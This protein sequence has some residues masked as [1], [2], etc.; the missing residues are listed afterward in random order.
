[1]NTATP[2]FA[3]QSQSQP[4]T[5]TRGDAPSSA[6]AAAGAHAEYEVEHD[7][8]YEYSSQVDFA[9]HLAHL[10]PVTAPG[11]A[12]HDFVLHVDPEPVRVDNTVDYFGNHR[13][14]F[15]LTVAHEVLR[16]RASSRVRLLPRFEELDPQVSAPWEAVRSALQYE[17]GAAFAPAA[18]FCFGSAFVPRDARLRAYALASFEPGRPLVAAAIDLMHRIHRDFRY[19][20][21]STDVATPVLEAFEARAGVCQDFTHVM[22]GCLRSLGL[23][24]RYVSGYLYTRARFAQT[25]AESPP[26]EAGGVVG[27]DASHAWVAVYCPHLGWVELDPTNDAIPGTGHVRLASGRDYGDVA[28][29]RGVVRGGGEHVLRVAVRLRAVAGPPGVATE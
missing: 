13:T 12:V 16:V 9:Q 1:M 24:A 7:T 3:S 20:A 6:Q 14:Y 8:E 18:E 17:A 15:A 5:G 28:P 22:I 10:T 29:L 23:A 11:Q 19:A 4:A 2:A 21:G 26:E 25:G 27:A